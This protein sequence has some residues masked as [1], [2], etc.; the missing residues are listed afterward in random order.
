ML[1]IRVWALHDVVDEAHDGMTCRRCWR[2][3]HRATATS[4]KA[5]QRLN[6]AIFKLHKLQAKSVG[7]TVGFDSVCT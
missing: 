6:F 2:L 7:R 3:Y 1:C 5:Q 4:T